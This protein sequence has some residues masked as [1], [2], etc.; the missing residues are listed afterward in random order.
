[1]TSEKGQTMTRKEIETKKRE[2]TEILKE[3]SARSRLE[4]LQK[5]AKEVGASVTRMEKIPLRH[6]GTIHAQIVYSNPSNE[7]TETEIVH[8]IQ[9]ALQT[10]TMIDMCK[11]AS[12]NFIIALAASAIALLSTIATWVMALKK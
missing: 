6:D 2:L 5:L 11:T 3:E 12:R 7:I 4:K 1:M 9:V 10:E 8:N